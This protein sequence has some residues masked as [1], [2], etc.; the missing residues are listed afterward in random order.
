MVAPVQHDSLHTSLHLL[1]RHIPPPPGVQRV[2]QTGPHRNNDQREHRGPNSIQL[3]TLVEVVYHHQ[4]LPS[5][6]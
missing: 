4:K 2:S 6:P 3:S 1:P 5:C